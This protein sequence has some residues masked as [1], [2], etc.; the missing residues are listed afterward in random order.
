MNSILMKQDRF[1]SNL[2]NTITYQT[3]LTYLSNTI[4][5]LKNVIPSLK[6]PLESPKQFL[7][8]ASRKEK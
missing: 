5:K 4:G 6:T 3:Y 2:S 7:N 1:L 8:W